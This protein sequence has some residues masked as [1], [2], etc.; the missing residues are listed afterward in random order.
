MHTKSCE[1]ELTK[2]DMNLLYEMY[3]FRAL[4]T[5]Q[6]MK[7]GQLGKWY[8]YKKL[9]Q[10]REK[11]YVITEHVKGDYFVGQSRQGNSHRVSSRAINLLKDNGYTVNLTA[12]DIRISS[13]RLPYLLVGNELCIHLRELGW[14]FTD[15][16]AIKMFKQLNRGDVLHGT[17]TNPGESKEYSI[18]VFLKS[19]LPKTLVRVKKE[20]MRT[21]FENVLVVTRGSES[22]QSVIKSFTDEKDSLIKGGSVKVLPFQF[23]KSYLNISSD[24][25]KNHEYFLKKLGLKV[26]CPHSSKNPFETNVRFDYLVEYKGEE[27]YFMDMLDNDLMKLNLISEYR[28][29]R[30]ERDGRKILVLTSN[31]SFHYNFHKKSLNHIKHVKF[32]PLGANQV[33]SFA[34]ELSSKNLLG[35]E[36]GMEM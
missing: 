27:M 31:S 36:G 30:Y 3:K 17:I 11:G 16:R 29:E 18:Y 10:L 20:I 34:N 21:P 32:M 15:S 33:V 7:V 35:D 5:A 8:V 13:Y 26:L 24:N 19:V 22:Y 14:H 12:D 9:S 25:R 23:A 28:K 6:V 1:N 4:S 2:R